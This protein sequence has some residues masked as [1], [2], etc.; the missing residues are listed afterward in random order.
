MKASILLQPY[1]AYLS[2]GELIMG[3]L[4]ISAGDVELLEG[5]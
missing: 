3:S 4:L 1:N 2:I 5:F